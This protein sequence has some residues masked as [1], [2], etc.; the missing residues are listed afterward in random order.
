MGGARISAT[1]LVN[2]MI[3]R[4]TQFSQT[5]R[6][7]FFRFIP[8]PRELREVVGYL[9]SQNIATEIGRRREI[10]YKRQDFAFF[11]D[12]ASSQPRIDWRCRRRVR[13]SKSGVRLQALDS[14]CGVGPKQLKA[15]KSFN[16]K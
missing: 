1:R 13:A 3:N 7:Y 12:I 8:P 16:G 15:P 2:Q 6:S 14:N 10:P 9:N 4:E 5:I 11:P